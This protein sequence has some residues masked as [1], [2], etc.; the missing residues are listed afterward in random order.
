[1]EP[2]NAGRLAS[3]DLVRGLA[4]VLMALDHVRDMLTQP[5]AADVANG[6]DFGRSSAVLFFTRWVTHFCAPTFVLLAGTSA[7]LYG[8]RRSRGELA[9]FLLTRGAWLVLIE[10]TVINLGWKFH[11]GAPVILQV[12]WAIGCSM[13]ALAGLVFLPRAAIAAIGAALIVG[14]NAVDAIQPAAGEASAAWLLLH[15]QGVMLPGGLPVLVLYPLVPWIGVM[16]VGY[17]L[18]P[19]F[20][21]PDPARAR[22]LVLGGLAA[23]LAFVGLRGF[24]LYGEPNPW[25]AGAGAAATLV[26][27]L[28]VTKY[29]PSLQ[30]LLMTLG[31]AV[32]ALGAL[33]GARG[34]AAAALATI[35]RVPFFYYVVHLYAIHALA[36]AV[37]LVQ[38]F[39]AGEMAVLFLDYPKGFGVSLGG[40]YLLWVAVILALYPACAWFARVKAR[41]RAWWMSYL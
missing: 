32:F 9:R 12:I 31:P 3:I 7:Y 14:H 23:T 17:A 18:G 24:G 22:R 6:L 26:D 1:M 19:L 13:I 21:A 39:G 29:P 25:A 11:L 10:L 15:V 8:A 34:R 2:R 35:G 4:M 36:I 33:E 5:L 37:G 30:Y 40:A 20:A 27:F 38:G 41:S 28:D 16:A